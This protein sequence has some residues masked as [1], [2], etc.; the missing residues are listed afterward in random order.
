MIQQI[1][2]VRIPGAIDGFEVAVRAILGQ[3]ITVKAATT[4]AG[5]FAAAFGTPIETPYP[6]LTHLFP[7]PERVAELTVD[8]VA[9]HGIIQ[10]RAECIIE[11]ARQLTT[12]ELK[13]TASTSH[14]IIAGMTAIKGIGPWTAN[15]VAMR[16][17]HWPDSFPKEDVVLRKKMGGLSAKQAEAVSQKW[18]PWRS[19]AAMY[20]WRSS[21]SFW[22]PDK[23]EP[24]HFATTKDSSNSAS[25]LSALT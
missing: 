9:S 2:G 25:P 15:Y 17:I 22:G 3:Q 1:P 8:D 5:R 11:I 16:V 4:L 20:V 13:L 24:P 10:R 14:D 7:T 6:N 23:K 12:G 18:R 21:F 19:Y